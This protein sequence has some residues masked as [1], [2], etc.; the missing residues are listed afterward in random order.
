MAGHVS[1]AYNY[2]S[3]DI[4]IQ[5]RKGFFVYASTFYHGLSRS[6]AVDWSPERLTESSP[7][8]TS[9]SPSLC[10]VVALLQK[11]FYDD[12]NKVFKNLVGFIVPVL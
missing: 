8:S 10:E 7:R 12:L 9:H 6:V 1:A 3:V 2:N 4:R 5:L 11:T